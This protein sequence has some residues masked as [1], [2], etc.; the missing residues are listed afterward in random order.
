VSAKPCGVEQRAPPIFGWTAIT[1]CIGPHSSIWL[2]DWKEI[3]PVKIRH[4]FCVLEEAEE[5][6]NQGSPGKQ[7]LKQDGGDTTLCRW[8][9]GF[10][11]IQTERSSEN[12]CHWN[13]VNVV[14]KNGRRDGLDM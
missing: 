14:I 13:H 3:W 4:C 8:I 6:A 5:M 1:L 10:T 7:L 11:W 12:F 2:G 9:C